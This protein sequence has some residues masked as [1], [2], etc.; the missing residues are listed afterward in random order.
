MDE[1]NLLLTAGQQLSQSSPRQIPCPHNNK[2]MISVI[3]EGDNMKVV[4]CPVLKILNKGGCPGDKCPHV[5]QYALGC[6]FVN[7]KK[8][9]GQ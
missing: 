3:G 5:Y 7:E 4:E 8:I 1:L 9:L 2:C 6:P